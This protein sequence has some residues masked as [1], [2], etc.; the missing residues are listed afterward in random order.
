M[1]NFGPNNKAGMR[2]GSFGSGTW[3][4]SIFHF[5]QHFQL[6][7]RDH[8]IGNLGKT[9]LCRIELEW[10]SVEGTVKWAVSAWAADILTSC[11]NRFSWLRFGLGNLRQLSR[12]SSSVTWY[13]L[14]T[15]CEAHATTQARKSI[16]TSCCCA[17]TFV[18]L[19]PWP[20]LAYVGV[21]RS[22]LVNLCQ[23]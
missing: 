2:T 23:H 22:A 16:Y 8:V 6:H 19:A 21:T 11:H 3:H 15:R 10:K 18:L 4:P 9:N 14:A 17:G 13:S 1:K 20:A 5:W 12:M 7:R